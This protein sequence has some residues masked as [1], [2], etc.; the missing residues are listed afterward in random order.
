MN[1]INTQALEPNLY[2]NQLLLY[3]DIA[4]NG[5]VKLKECSICGRNF[6]ADRLDTHKKIC[7]S[8]SKKRKQ[9]DS[10][11]MRVEGTEAEKYVEKKKKSK[12][13]EKPAKPNNWRKK[14]EEFIETVRYAKAVS[15]V[16]RDGGNIR[17]IP[18]P[19][20]ASNSDYIQCP[21]CGRKF[22]EQAG[23]RHIPICKEKMQVPNAI[24]KNG[25]GRI[26]VA[27]GARR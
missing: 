2:S 12:Q 22:N 1:N 3:I 10:V 16:E 14:H 15:Q 20:A 13:S 19:A 27:T 6:A 11:K 17:D 18:K 26:P 7:K 4:P 9:F 21:K 5:N 23:N 25:P 8:T 24:A